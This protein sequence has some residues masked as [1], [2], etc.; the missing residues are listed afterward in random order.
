LNF[1]C[2]SVSTSREPDLDSGEP[3]LKRGFLEAAARLMPTKRDRSRCQVLK[4]KVSS[5]EPRRAQ[6]RP[7]RNGRA[8]PSGIAKM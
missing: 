6:E 3:T 1:S 5:F 8:H 7:V 4:D 2:G